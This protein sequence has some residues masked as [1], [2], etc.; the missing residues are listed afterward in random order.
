M[1]SMERRIRKL[2]STLFL[3][4]SKCDTDPC[5]CD[6]LYPAEAGSSKDEP[7]ETFASKIALLQHKAKAERI[8]SEMQ[9]IKKHFSEGIENL[10]NYFEIVDYAVRYVEA[11]AKKV[12]LLLEAPVTS[13]FKK[14]LAISF[15]DT[16][17]PFTDQLI[18]FIVS[19]NF[20]KKKSKKLLK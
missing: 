6:K 4:C 3:E 9:T 5:T 14:E 18:D 19:K 16:V 2:E 1:K 11:N 8:E 12:S 20:P 7:K 17:E 13:I 10:K 15:I